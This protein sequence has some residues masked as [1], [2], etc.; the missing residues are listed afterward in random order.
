MPLLEA[1]C[2][3]TLILNQSIFSYIFML[4]WLRSTFLHHLYECQLCV[5]HVIYKYILLHDLLNS[6]NIST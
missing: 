6:G 1:E 5:Y 4:V 2:L 3:I